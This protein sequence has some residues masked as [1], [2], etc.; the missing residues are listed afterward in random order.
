MQGFAETI[1]LFLILKRL[2]LFRDVIPTLEI[3]TQKRLGTVKMRFYI[4]EMFWMPASC[5][6]SMLHSCQAC[7]QSS[8]HAKKI[9]RFQQGESLSY[10]LCWQPSGC[11]LYNRPIK[12]NLKSPSYMYCETQVMSHRPAHHMIHVE[13]TLPQTPEAHISAAPRGWRGGKGQGVGGGGAVT[14]LQQSAWG[15]GT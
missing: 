13:L 1:K 14:S 11:T 7:W 4:V 3:Y 8:I 10:I 15:L 6:G 12:T 5:M 9:F 2:F